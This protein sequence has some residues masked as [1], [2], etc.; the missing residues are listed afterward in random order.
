MRLVRSYINL[1][2]KKSK[3]NPPEELNDEDNK[4]MNPSYSL[5][6]QMMSV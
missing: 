1:G 2:L 3:K 5:D 4:Y 6:G